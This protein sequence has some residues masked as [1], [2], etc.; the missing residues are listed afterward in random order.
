MMRRPLSSLRW[1]TL[2]FIAFSF[3][4]S[5]AVHADSGVSDERVSLPDGPGSIGGVGENADVDP[6]MGMMRYNLPIDT[7]GGF[8]NATPTIKLSYASGSGAT[9]VGVGWN[10][11]ARSAIERMTLRGLPE[12][13]TDDE[14]QGP[15]GELVYVGDLEGTRVYRARFES[16][17]ARYRWYGWDTPGSDYWVVE[18]PNGNVQYYGADESGTTVGNARVQSG[19]DTFRYMLV[20]EFD[21]NDHAVRYTYTKSGGWPLLDTI[22]WVYGGGMTPRFSVRF[23]YEA[24]EDYISTAEPGFVIELQERLSE[25]AVFS[26]SERIRRYLLEYETQEA[27]GGASRLAN[28]TQRGRGDATTPIAF[29]FGYSRSLD[30]SCEGECD[31]PYMVEMGTLPGGVSL[32][33]GRATLLDINGDALPDVLSTSLSGETL[34][35]CRSSTPTP[36]TPPLARCAPAPPPSADPRSSSAPRGCRSST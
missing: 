17:F 1:T 2:A 35:S 13:T 15:S 36:A 25:V 16:G 32:S 34:G 6:N 30:G 24:R 28:V 22:G 20:V 29:S 27:S 21:V 18:M 26:S 8:P 4:V 3:S 10:L 33:N 9:E 31:G 7:L 23:G 19:T 12:Y 14:F 11:S 5:G